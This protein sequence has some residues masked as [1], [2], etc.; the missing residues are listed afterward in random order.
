[1]KAEAKAA[2]LFLAPALL[3]IF[4]FFLLPVI[5]ALVLSI[6]DFDIYALGDS[7]NIRLV[8][9]DNYK[10]LIDSPV[11]WKALRNTIYFALIG[12]PLTVA[13]ALGA[14]VGTGVGVAVLRT[15]FAGSLRE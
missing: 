2:W 13:V 12:G 9:F 14:R 15:S 8:A 10:E 5:A 6:T 4:V 11:F 3:L 1:M 7:S